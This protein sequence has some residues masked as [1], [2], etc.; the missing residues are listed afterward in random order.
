[1]PLLPDPERREKRYRVISVDDHFCEP[2]HMFDGRLPS[3]LLALAPRIVESESGTQTWEMEGVLYPT[4]GLNAVVGRPKEE[5]NFE[6]SR[7]DE[8]R[9]GAW[10]IHSRI[11]DM[12]LAGIDAAVCFPSLIAG[13]AGTKFSKLKNQELGLACVRAWNDFVIDEWCGTYPGRIIP[14]QI[15]W[16]NDPDVAAALI[17]ENAERGFRAV[18]L[19][20]SFHHNGYPSIHTDHWDP[21]LRACEETE[22]VICLHTGSGQWHATLSPEAPIEQATALFP[23]C[24]LA[25]AADWLWAKV[26]LRFPDVK[27]AMSEGGIGWVAMLLD[28]MDYMTNHELGS[29]G[30]AWDG[31]ISPSEALQRNF[32][33]CTIDDPSTVD[34][35]ERIGEDHVMLEVDYP[36]ASST[37]PDTQDFVERSLGH[38]RRD[39]IDKVTY[40]NAE[41]LFRWP[42]PA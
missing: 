4:I 17:R 24:G 6:P 20:E 30:S 28:R 25:A 21:V 8:M 39:L 31:D 29:I 35:I 36:H 18:S 33:F 9:K 32:W 23:A 26:P 15:T 5:W 7:F 13:F 38:L 14:L 37:W 10:D 19:P 3:H 16:L 42:L 2:A 41:N 12:D 22:T 27:I 11:A 40:R 34:T 1:M